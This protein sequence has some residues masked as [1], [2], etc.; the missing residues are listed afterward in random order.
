MKNFIVG[1]LVAVITFVAGGIIIN[2]DINLG[3]TPGTEHL[4]YEIFRNGAMIS[5]FV[6]GG[7]TVALTGTSTVITKDYACDGMTITHTST[8]NFKGAASTTLPAAA[9][10]NND[11]LT[12]NN[13]S[14]TFIF[15]NGNTLAASTTVLVV[16]STTRETLLGTSSASDIIA[17][18]QRVFITVVRTSATTVDWYIGGDNWADAD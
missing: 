1:A 4:N 3:A 5:G 2:Y 6:S 11:C 9:D 14:R 12:V 8:S 15:K 17:G 13:D 10:L 18:G 16:S 7:S